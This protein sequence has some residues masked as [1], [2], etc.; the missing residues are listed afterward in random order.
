M[1][2]KYPNRWIHLKNDTANFIHAMPNYVKTFYHSIFRCN[3]SLKNYDM[4]WILPETKRHVWKIRYSHLDIYIPDKM[5]LLLIVNKW[6]LSTFI[7]TTRKWMILHK[8]LDIGHVWHFQTKDKYLSRLKV[9]VLSHRIS[10]SNMVTNFYIYLI[11]P[12]NAWKS[13]INPH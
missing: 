13:E 12:L 3:L 8:K 2:N 5:F 1:M 6:Y 11:V 4:N 9:H 7:N 10:I